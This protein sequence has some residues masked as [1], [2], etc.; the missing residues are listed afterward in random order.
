LVLEYLTA[1]QEIGVV[2]EAKAPVN[3]PRK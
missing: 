3:E 1:L 2:E